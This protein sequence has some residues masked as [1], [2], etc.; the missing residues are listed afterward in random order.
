MPQAFMVLGTGQAVGKTLFCRALLHHAVKQGLKTSVFKPIDTGCPLVATPG[1]PLEIG[2]MPGPADAQSAAAIS[3]LEQLAG[4]IPSYILGQ[5][6]HESLGARDGKTLLEASGRTD[7]D[8]EDVSPH[9]FAPDLEPAICARYADTEISLDHLWGLAQDLSAGADLFLVEGVWSLMSPLFGRMT[10]L[11]LVKQLELPVVLVVPSLPGSVGPCLLTF[12]A[13]KSVGIDVHSVIIDR[14]RKEI[15][16]D[17]A[18]LPF[19]I[20]TYMGDVVRGVIPH[21]EEEQLSD[22]EY[23]SE[24]VRVHVDINRLL[25]DTE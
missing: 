4:P 22:L 3:R 5:T 1:R 25:F 19:Q 18:A 9:R 24:R 21:F 23:L 15:G 12:R 14:V 2:G 8:L 10:Q 11:D 16:F 13:L 7:L 20:E 6:P 17:E